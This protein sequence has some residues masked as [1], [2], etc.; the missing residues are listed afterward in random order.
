MEQTAMS[1]NPR[2]DNW[3]DEEL[4]DM[5]RI[6]DFTLADAKADARRHD[7]LASFLEADQVEG[8]DE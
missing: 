1:D 8:E 3:S 2:D 7:D 6:D 5:A 4:D